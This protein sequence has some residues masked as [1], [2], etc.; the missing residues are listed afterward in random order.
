MLRTCQQV[1][2]EC[3]S[4]PFGGACDTLFAPNITSQGGVQ[5]ASPPSS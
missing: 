1:S 4:C 2:S 5:R 3:R